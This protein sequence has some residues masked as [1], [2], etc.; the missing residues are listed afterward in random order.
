MPTQVLI[1][2]EKPSQVKTISNT[3]FQGSSQTEKVNN[4]LY[5]RKGIW[6]GKELV[7]IP[8]IGHITTI[9]TSEAFGWNKC[10]PIEIVTNH[11][12]L[13]L[14]KN[15]TFERIISQKARSAEDRFERLL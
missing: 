7:L 9:D 10:A 15:S 6:K 5:L 4:R 12:A 13:I 11:K 14:R 2:G 1:I 8:L 3:L